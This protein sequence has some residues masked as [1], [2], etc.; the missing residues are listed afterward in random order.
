MKTDAIRILILDEADKL[1]EK[2]FAADVTTIFNKLPRCKQIIA[3]S[4]TFPGELAEVVEK[5]MR[6]PT[7]VRLA[8]EDQVMLNELNSIVEPLSIAVL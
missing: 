1:M 5:Y 6:N 2:T 3:A 8:K 4:A 7:H